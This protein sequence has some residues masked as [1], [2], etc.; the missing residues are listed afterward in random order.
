MTERL[1][2]Y[3]IRRR[4]LAGLLLATLVAWLVTLVLSYRDTRHE[5][6]ELL[7]AHLAQSASLLI[8]Q[9]GHEADDIDSEHAPQLHRYSRTVAFQIW[10]RG[11]R[12]L[13]HSAGSPNTPLSP[14]REGFSDNSI[15][16]EKW[17]VFSAWDTSGRYLIQVGE[18]R[19]ARDELAGTIAENLLL[20]VAITLPFLGL[21]IWFGVTRGLRPLSILSGEVARRQPGNLSP[22]DLNTVPTE[23]L[24]LVQ[25]L[26]RLFERVSES[27]DRERRFT[28][29]AAHELRTPLAAIRTQA[30]VASAAEADIE[31]QQALAKVIEGCDRVA[32]LVDQ[33]LTLAR[34]E[35]EQSRV[36]EECDLR[37]IARETV[38]ELAPAAIDRGVDLNLS[39]KKGITVRGVPPLIGILMRNL[40]DNAI[41]YS[42]SGSQ[43]NISIERSPGGPVISVSDQ[44]PGIP[45]EAQTRVWDRFY[46][47]LGTGES[48]SG[49][50]LSIVK[51]IADL[52]S[53]DTS[54]GA[55]EGG[56]GLQ[57][58]VTFRSD[59]SR[60]AGSRRVDQGVEK[61]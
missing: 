4:L 8:A 35:P 29:D 20:P 16:G 17:R 38:A 55:G 7:D 57:V 51:R 19:E 32:H 3:S 11:N 47:V 2:S 40:I 22:L 13:L 30:Q 27:F 61:T 15:N 6:D 14:L 37:V 25:D 1:A 39:A 18:Q 59:P 9:I 52:H 43:V 28:A 23:V 50:G 21:L 58:S 44:G 46:R 31:Q 33:L 26:N 42:P 45:V 36:D 41:R 54:L 34:L 5:L 56:K 24:P 48:G 53:A 10:Y 49:L 60:G 12:L